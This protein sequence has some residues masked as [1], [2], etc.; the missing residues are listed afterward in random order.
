MKNKKMNKTIPI[1]VLFLLI[2]QLTYSQ[3][4]IDGH[5]MRLGEVFNGKTAV[6]IQTTETEGNPFFFDEFVTA[7]LVSG[8]QQTVPVKMNVDLSNKSIVV[9]QDNKLVAIQYAAVNEIRITYPKMTLKNGFTTN[10][11][12]DLNNRTF[13]EVIHEGD[14]T[15]LK[16]TGV[17]LQKD[18]SSYGNAVQ[19]DVYS[20]FTAYYAIVDGEFKRIKMRKRNIL[21]LFGDN[22]K[23]VD[24]YAKDNKLDFKNDKHLAEM[25]TYASNL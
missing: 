18:V 11:V 25:F 16:N 5:G 17:T 8:K 13:F 7:V 20:K 2:S 19:Q 3:D 15:F 22:R 14:V 9:S 12:D 24:K 10:G 1:A 23:A 21:R 4:T 6:A